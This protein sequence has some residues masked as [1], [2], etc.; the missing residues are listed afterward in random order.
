MI[1]TVRFGSLAAFEDFRSRFSETM[2][3]R[4]LSGQHLDELC[5]EQ[6]VLPG[7]CS[8]CCEP[9]LFAYSL[10]DERPPNLREG[11]A[12]GAG[13]LSARVRCALSLLS[14]VQASAGDLQVYVTEQ[15]SPLYRYL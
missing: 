8:V 3:M 2:K 1:D 15:A 6:G 4:W 11:L 10:V 13:G 5:R 12:C 7:Y 14:A 9:S